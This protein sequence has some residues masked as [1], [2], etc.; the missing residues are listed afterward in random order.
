MRALLVLLLLASPLYGQTILKVQLHSGAVVVGQAS[1]LEWPL[2]TKYGVLKIPTS[3]VRYIKVGLHY[4]GSLKDDIHKA[5]KNLSSDVYK[6]R[7]DA[8]KALVLWSKYTLPLLP[9]TGANSEAA[10]RIDQIRQKIAESDADADK[11]DG[12]DTVRTLDFEV[13]GDLEMTTL[14]V[15]SDDFDTPVKIKLSRIAK[16]NL[17]RPLDESVSV[18]ANGKWLDIG[19]IE[20]GT[21]LRLQAAGQVDLWPQGP[22]QYVANPKGYNTTGKGGQFMAGALIMRIGEAPSTFVGES[23]TVTINQSGNLQLF[24]VESPWNSPSIGSYKVS[25]KGE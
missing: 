22:G 25:I 16:I 17:V 5:V 23:A 1:I 19:Y 13:Q 2:K 11:F 8:S 20:A 3:D 14:T 7:D 9:K 15:T 24:I 10:V 21:K 18:P 6:I 4:D 12:F